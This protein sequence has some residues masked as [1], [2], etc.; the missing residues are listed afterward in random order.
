MGGGPECSVE[1]VRMYLYGNIEGPG[2]TQYQRQSSKIDHQEF[3]MDFSSL[4]SN[5]VIRFAATMIAVDHG[6]SN[7]KTDKKEVRREVLDLAKKLTGLKHSKLMTADRIYINSTL[8][9]TMARMS[10][11]A[12]S[13]TIPNFGKTS[14]FGFIV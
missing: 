11:T 1:S 13:M 12:E 5:S 6:E 9:P 7:L 14:V 4:S 8:T 10:T 2:K 3:P